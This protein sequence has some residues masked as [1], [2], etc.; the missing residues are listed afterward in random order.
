M[1]FLSTPHQALAPHKHSR[2]HRKWQ[3][4]SSNPFIMQKKNSWSLSFVKTSHIVSTFNTDD[5]QP[6]LQLE[7]SL[8][9]E[10]SSQTTTPNPSATNNINTI[11]KNLHNIVP[12]RWLASSWG[13]AN[14]NATPIVPKYT[15]ETT[16]WKASATTHYNIKNNHST[17]WGFSSPHLPTHQVHRMFS[18]SNI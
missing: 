12:T 13:I 17:H 8:L 9:S 7:A 5:V 16:L 4:S 15:I 18:L 10:S 3:S 2:C 14:K 1:S 6:Q 11:H